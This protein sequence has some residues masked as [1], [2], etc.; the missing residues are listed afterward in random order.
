M[1]YYIL[2]PILGAIIGYFTNYIAVK[3]LFRPIEAVNIPI[4]NLKIQGLLPRRRDELAVNIAETID[5]NLLSIDNIIDE[6]DQE[7]IKGE[8][9][10]IIEDTISK[11]I[12]ENF[13]YV[14]PRLLKD[15]SREII[16]DVIKE[17]V[18]ANF[19]DWM[20][21]LTEKVKNEVDIKKMIEEKIKS[22]PMSTLEE[23]ILKIADKELKHI[24]YLGGLIGFIIGLGQL[25]LIT[26]I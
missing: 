7:V 3:M 23:I 5:N 20:E 13:K 15:I 26:W 4:F 1:N 17:E 12:N 6:F 21:S 10:I 19:E 11:K 9:D 16:V 25:L 22:F 2:I 14:M 24:E 8:L 18:H